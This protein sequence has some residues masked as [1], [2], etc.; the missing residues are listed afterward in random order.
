VPFLLSLPRHV[1][2]RF[3]S[4]GAVYVAGCVGL[5][6][7]GGM[8]FEQ[9]GKD[10]LYIAFATLEELMEMTGIVLFIRAL[11]LYLSETTS[12]LHLSFRFSKS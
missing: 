1:M 3:V 6:M 4:A 2:Y 8:R 9:F 10:P 7:L 12:D 5:E 11:I